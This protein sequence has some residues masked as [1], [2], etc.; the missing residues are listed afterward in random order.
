MIHKI[1]RVHPALCLGFFCYVYLFSGLI[2]NF[3]QLLIFIFIRSVSEKWGTK[4]NG[5][6]QASHVASKSKR[7]GGLA[8]R[9]HPSGTIRWTKGISHDISPNPSPNPN[10]TRALTLKNFFQHR[11]KDPDFNIFIFIRSVSEKWGT[12][13]N[14]ILQA[15]H[16]AIFTFVV[17]WHCECNIRLYFEEESIQYSNKEHTL[18]I[19]NHQ[20]EVDWQLGY[21]LLERLDGLKGCKGLIKKQAIFLPVV[22]WYMWFTDYL[23]LSRNWV[24]DQS[25]IRKICKTWA[26]YDPVENSNFYVLYGEGTRWTPAKHEA[27]VKFAKERGLEP[28]KHVLFPRTK[29]AVEMIYELGESLGSV[30]NVVFA[31]PGENKPDT[32]T[33]FAGKATDIDIYF[34]RVGSEEIPRHD[35]E[36]LAKFVIDHYRDKDN[37][38]QYHAENDA[39]PGKPT[40]LPRRLRSL[41]MFYVWSI[42][43]VGLGAVYLNYLITNEYHSLLGLIGVGFIL[44]P[45]FTNVKGGL[46]HNNYYQRV[47]SEEI[48]RHDKEELAKFVIDHY[49][50]KDNLLQ[51]HAENDAFPGKPTPL[52]R[53]LR[54][55]I[56]FYVWS[57]V[58]VGLG[59]V[60][61]NYLITNEYHSLLGLIGVGFILGKT[62]DYVSSAPFYKCKR[63]VRT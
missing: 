55:L 61:L 50:D 59:A 30:Q 5:I 22:G 12:K 25:A 27:A 3:L 38:L 63:R 2:V 60:Y 21:T 16:V 23:F 36:E 54:S 49:R 31:F 20:G 62:L 44:A 32:G 9:I 39:F 4:L 29:G 41:I 15:S 13:L 48:P 51:Y 17:E 56:M 43:S 6:L 46:E 47:G 57:I 8:T 45:P 58:S 14:G 26:K 35:K 1:L 53:R 10:P 24:K 18:C 34:R 42:V 19:C 28:F 33:M 7:G 11:R 52:P 37:L 40:P